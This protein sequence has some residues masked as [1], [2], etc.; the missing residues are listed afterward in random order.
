MAAKHSQD[1]E[2]LRTYVEPDLAAWVKATA[3]R[4]G[5]TTSSWLRWVLVQLR[6]EMANPGSGGL[7]LGGGVPSEPT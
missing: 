2:V 3:N 4:N 6:S 7:I 1:N 5:H